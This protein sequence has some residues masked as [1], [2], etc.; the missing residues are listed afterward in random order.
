M[1][2]DSGWPAREARALLLVAADGGVPDG[3]AVR[4]DRAG[5][6][7]AV[8][9][10]GYQPW[11]LQRICRRRSGGI[12]ARENWAPTKRYRALEVSG[13][14]ERTFVGDYRKRSGRKTGPSA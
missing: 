4:G 6:D 11:S 12:R 9:T 8:G 7:G 13:G 14:C 10:R 5:V 1:I 3:A 2:A